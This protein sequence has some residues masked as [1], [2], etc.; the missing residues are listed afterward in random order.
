M[1]WHTINLVLWLVMLGALLVPT[2]HASVKWVAV[3]GLVVAAFWEHAA[4][5]GFL[6]HKRREGQK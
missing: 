2:D 1:I 6:R 3:V 5:R 4:V